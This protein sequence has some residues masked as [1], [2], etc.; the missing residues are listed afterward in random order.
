MAQSIQDKMKAKGTHD[1]VKN[2]ASDHYPSDAFHELHG[3]LESSSILV[4][5]R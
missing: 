2:T 4:A 1:E 3:D 5:R